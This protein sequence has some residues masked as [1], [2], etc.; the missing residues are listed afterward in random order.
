MNRPCTACKHHRDHGDIFPGTC[1]S[2]DVIPITGKYPV[3]AFLQR[4]D[5][6]FAAIWN[7][8]CGRRGRFFEDIEYPILN[9][10]ANETGAVRDFVGAGWPKLAPLVRP[11]EHDLTAKNAAARRP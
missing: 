9:E 10:L 6:F 8:S 5:G 11:Q 2:L 4:S 3:I 1:K 7:G